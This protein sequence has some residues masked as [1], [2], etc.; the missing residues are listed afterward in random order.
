MGGY[1]ARHQPFLIVCACGILSKGKRR[2]AFDELVCV[3]VCVCVCA[4]VCACVCVRVCACVRVRVCAC[5]CVCVCVCVSEEGEFGVWMSQC[6]PI[7]LS[8]P[9]F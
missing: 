8:M 5:V 1:S 4:R 3:C 2:G 6:D 7:W 9:F